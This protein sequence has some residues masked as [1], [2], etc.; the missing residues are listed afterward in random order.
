MASNQWLVAEEMEACYTVF[1]IFIFLVI[2]F[3][4]C[5]SDDAPCEKAF[6]PP[7]LLSAM[8]EY[9]K[10]FMMTSHSKLSHPGKKRLTFSL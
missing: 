2:F 1:F 8:F 5:L 4:F 3:P 9:R 10:A 7:S 6:I